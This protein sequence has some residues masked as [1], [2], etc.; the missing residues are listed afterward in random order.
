ML[1]MH[2]LPSLAGFFSDLF[3][4]AHKLVHMFPKDPI[5]WYAVGCYY[6][7]LGKNN[8]ARRYLRLVTLQENP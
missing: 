6:L 7:L 5:A 1:T 3:Y 8:A 2:F 4:L